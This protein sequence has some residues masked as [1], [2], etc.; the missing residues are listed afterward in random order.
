[1]V[2]SERFFEL[3]KAG[4][5]EAPQGEFDDVPIFQALAQRGELLAAPFEGAI[6]DVGR[7]EGYE[8]AVAGFPS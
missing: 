5:E 4:R 1:V 7:P 3:L 6:F 8:A 2:V